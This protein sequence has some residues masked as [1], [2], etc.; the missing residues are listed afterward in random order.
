MSASIAF[1][2]GDRWTSA[3][4]SATAVASVPSPLI[5][6]NR[7]VGGQIGSITN[8]PYQVSFRAFGKHQCGGA[9]V[10]PKFVLT[11]AHCVDGVLPSWASVRAGF[12]KLNDPDG[13]IIEA[14]RFI[15][16]PMFRIKTMSNDIAIVVLKR[17]FVFSN[18]IQP[19]RL[20]S[21]N[22]NYSPG[23][24][25]VT[26]GWGYLWESAS[27][28]SNLL[29]F[30]KV[31]IVDSAKCRSVYGPE[32]VTD[33]QICAGNGRGDACQGDSGGPLA[34]DGILIGIVSFGNGCNRQGFPGVYTKIAHYRL[35]LQRYIR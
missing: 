7:I 15:A 10:R 16:H 35:W 5:T 28:P 30:V 11:A 6:A 32:A 12:N 9:I 29:Q 25:A 26:S 27:Q 2:A 19:I 8:Y 14:S 17:P 21:P 13:T 1:N 33:A 24:Y 23:E 18:V 31:P 20:P 3:A 4:V 22:A 34:M